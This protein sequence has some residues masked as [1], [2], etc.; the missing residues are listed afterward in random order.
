ML[1]NDA[2]TLPRKAVILSQL[3]HNGCHP[4]RSEGSVFSMLRLGSQLLQKRRH[5]ERSE[6]K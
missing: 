3:P 2:I 1:L 5:P 6:T 4:E